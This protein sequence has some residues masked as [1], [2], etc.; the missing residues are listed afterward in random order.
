MKTALIAPCGMNCRTYSFSRRDAEYAENTFFS[1]KEHQAFP[2]RPWRAQQEMPY[3]LALAAGHRMF[4]NPSSA[5]DAGSK[6][7]QP[8]ER[9]IDIFLEI[10]LILIYSMLD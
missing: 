4:I 5:P 10:S 1:F 3:G 6:P 7:A 8:Q 9:Q 2:L